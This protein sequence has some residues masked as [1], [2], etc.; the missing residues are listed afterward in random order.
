MSTVYMGVKVVLLKCKSDQVTLTHITQ[1][2]SQSPSIRPRSC[3]IQP[4]L[5]P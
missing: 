2:D 1:S 4:L 3:L 5:P